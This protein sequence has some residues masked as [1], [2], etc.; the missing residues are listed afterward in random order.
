MN[1]KERP[2][3]GIGVIIVKDGKIAVGKR[4]ASHGKDTYMIPGGHLEFGEDIKV[5]AKREVS[6]ECGLTDITIL[7][8][9]SVSNDIAYDKHYVSICVLAEWHSGELVDAEPHKSKNW[10][11][12]DPKNLAEPFFIPSKRGIENWLAGKVYS[13]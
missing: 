8:V 3:V 4:I 12:M 6:E 9:V 5:C 11:W 10:Q 13:Q 7:D 1:P 2:F